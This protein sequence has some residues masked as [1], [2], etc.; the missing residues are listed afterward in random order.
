MFSETELKWFDRH[1]KRR[2]ESISHGVSPDDISGR[3][4][5]LKPYSWRLKGN[6]LIG[7]TEMGPLVQNIPPDRILVGQDEQG[8]PRFERVIVQK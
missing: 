8:L 3:M 5:Q 2:P 7:M 1:N 6:Q 4:R